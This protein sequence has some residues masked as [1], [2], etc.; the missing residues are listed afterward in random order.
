[1]LIK[2]IVL[3]FIGLCSG[4]TV[5][6]GV[7]AFITMLGIIPRLATRTHTRKHIYLYEAAI[8]WGGALGNIWILYQISLPLTSLFLCAIGLFSGMFVGCL[9]MALAE[10]I[11]VFPIMTNR[12]QLREG[13]P[14][15][16]IAVAVG[17]VAGTLFQFFY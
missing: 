10:V 16:V 9:A 3:A 8:I 12:I 11:R 2:Q 1:M 7:F 5:A 13:F 17:K 15:V 4:L 14:M 6:A